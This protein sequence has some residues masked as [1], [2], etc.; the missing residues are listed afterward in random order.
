M[1]VFYNIPVKKINTA[2]LPFLDLTCLNKIKKLLNYLNGK[3]NIS[4]IYSY[5]YTLT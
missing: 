2:A 4:C 5:W 1:N 3:T